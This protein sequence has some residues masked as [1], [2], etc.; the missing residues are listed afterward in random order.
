M[1]SDKRADRRRFKGNCSRQA[2]KSSMTKVIEPSPDVEFQFPE[3]PEMIR[4]GSP[5]LPGV[6]GI[7]TATTANKMRTPVGGG[8]T[9]IRRNSCVH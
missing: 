4:T 3:R 7:E 9:S 6:V 5:L 8:G 1:G 2:D